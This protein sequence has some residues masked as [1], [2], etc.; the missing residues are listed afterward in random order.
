MSYNSVKSHQLVT[1]NAQVFGFNLVC[2]STKVPRF[3]VVPSTNNCVVSANVAINTY[4]KNLGG[5]YQSYD[6][7]KKI[8]TGKFEL[9]VWC[10]EPYP[11]SKMTT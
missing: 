6:N 2:G 5:V 11:P 7:L 8:K 10:T 3:V 4:M 9:G 1:A